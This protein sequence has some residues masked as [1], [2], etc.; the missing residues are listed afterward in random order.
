MTGRKLNKFFNNMTYLKASQDISSKD[1]KK[2]KIYSTP[3]CIYC[4]MAKDFFDNNSL[5]Y[6]EYDVSK[7][8]GKREEMVEKSGQW[9]VPVIIIGDEVM[10][11]F[12]KQRIVELIEK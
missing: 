3:S 12:D 8:E 9:G 2:I 1:E 4:K 7:N 10:V 5:D 11:G 6:E